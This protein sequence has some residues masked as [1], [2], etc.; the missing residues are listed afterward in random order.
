MSSR[1]I[2]LSERER[3]EIK[4]GGSIRPIDPSAELP[5]QSRGSSSPPGGDARPLR[6]CESEILER[7]RHVLGR[8]LA[9]LRLG[10]ISKS[11]HD[12]GLGT[13]LRGNRGLGAFGSERGRKLRL[14]ERSNDS[15]PSASRAPIDKLP[16][17]A[18]PR[19]GTSHSQGL[20]FQDVQSLRFSR[21][22]GPNRVHS[23]A[24]ASSR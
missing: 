2:K 18:S 11:D 4:E 20:P 10:G 1:Q 23:N 12:R 21:T 8:R 16:V 24:L 22:S 19:N 17:E 6:R 14:G 3:Y 5:L 13:D 9:L 15:G 7:R